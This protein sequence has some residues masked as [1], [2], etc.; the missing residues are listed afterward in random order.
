MI[1]IDEIYLNVFWSYFQKKLPRTRL[2]FLDPFGCTSLENVV[3][4]SNLG[5]DVNYIFF[6]DQEPI[7]LDVHKPMLNHVIRRNVDV[8]EN[9]RLAE[10][11]G[12][13][14]FHGEPRHETIAQGFVTS[15]R[16]SEFVEEVCRTFGWK[17]YYY[18]FHGWAALDWF[19]GY[20][21]AFSITPADQRT[22]KNSFISPNRIIGGRRQHRV[23]LMYHLLKH[24]INRALISF[25]KE[26]PQE[27]VSV[28]DICLQHLAKYPDIQTVFSQAQLPWDFPK[29]SGHPMKSYQLDLF[30]ECSESLAYV[31]TETVFNG[32]RLHLTEKTFKPICMQMPF[33]LVST[34]GS[35]RYLRDYGFRTFSDFWDESY[36]DE[37]DDDR[38]LEKIAQLLEYIDS[39]SLLELNKM[40]QAMLP[41]IRHNYEHFYQGGFADILWKELVDMLEEIER[42]HRQ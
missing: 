6:Q 18:F 2:F 40:H 22:I 29:E 41:V 14:T 33:V 34:A 39:M 36:D 30:E 31:V 11:R 10:Q 15:E 8:I 16:D 4:L 12:G 19:R 37:H 7:H 1:R 3:G 9:H 32:R 35:L 21:R 5:H 13:N 23:L 24:G 26:C 17:S 42:D 27:H 28:N 25:P 38:R 20:D